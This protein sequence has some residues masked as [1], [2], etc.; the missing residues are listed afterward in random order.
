MIMILQTE[1]RWHR[2][3]RTEISKKNEQLMERRNMKLKEDVCYFIIKIYY[4]CDVFYKI[5]IK[6]FVDITNSFW[7]NTHHDFAII[8]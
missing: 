6:K 3:R 7:E 4:S 5:L 1:E 2:R 8:K